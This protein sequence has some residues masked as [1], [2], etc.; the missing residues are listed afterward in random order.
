M[1]QA[2]GST[3][4]YNVIIIFIVITFCFL[5]ATLSYMKSYKMNGK[6][7]NLL[8]KYEGYN[9]LSAAEIETSLSNLGYRISKDGNIS[10][11]ERKH[12]GKTYSPIKEFGTNYKYCIYEYPKKDGYFT[13]GI[14][15]YIY[16]DI[17]IASGTFSL[18]VYAETE[19]IY[20]FTQK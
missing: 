1:R 10:C 14:V 5:A 17:P 12:N 2:I 9:T 6:I 15:T 4:L 18:P 16:M 19:R 8:E 11:S 13:Y 3:F 20:E 7:A